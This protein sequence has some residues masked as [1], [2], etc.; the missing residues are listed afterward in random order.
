MPPTRPTFKGEMKKERKRGWTKKPE[1]V[2]K[3][4]KHGR[5]KGGKYEHKGYWRFSG[6]PDRGRLEH[7]V[8]VR[9]MLKEP[10]GL[11]CPTVEQLEQGEFEIHHADFRRGHNCKGN[12]QVLQ[13]CIHRAISGFKDRKNRRK[14]QVCSESEESYLKEIAGL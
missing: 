3:G 5:W 4:E 1:Q 11:Q 13:T 10:L 2:V 7:L 9:E 14:K 6:G 12:L 8:I